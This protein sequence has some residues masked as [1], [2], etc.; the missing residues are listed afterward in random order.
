MVAKKCEVRKLRA[1]RQ[2]GCRAL[3]RDTGAFDMVAPSAKFHPF[4]NRATAHGV[5]KCIYKYIRLHMCTS[6]YLY[7]HI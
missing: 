1:S 2:K 3:A 5:H 6:M 4:I 7:T